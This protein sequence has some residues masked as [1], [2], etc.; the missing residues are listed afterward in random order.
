MIEGAVRGGVVLAEMM[1]SALYG[2]DWTEGG[3]AGEAVFF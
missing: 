1:Y 2:M 3:I